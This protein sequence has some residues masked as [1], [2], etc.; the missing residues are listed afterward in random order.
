MY[1]HKFDTQLDLGLV[2]PA[3]K[4][5]TECMETYGEHPL[6]LERLALINMVKGNTSAAKIYLKA[7]SM[8]RNAAGQ[9]QSSIRSFTTLVCDLVKLP[10][11]IHKEASREEPAYYFRPWKTMLVRT[12]ADGGE[13]YYVRGRHHDTIPMLWSEVTAMKRNP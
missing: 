4:N 12:T 6:L 11:N 3:Q 7:L 8:V 5:F 13:S 10:M 1:W 9:N 2:N